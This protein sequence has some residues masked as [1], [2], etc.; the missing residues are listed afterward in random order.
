MTSQLGLDQCFLIEGNLASRGQLAMSGDIF[1]YQDQDGMG[2][3][4]GCC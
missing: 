4:L 2:R 3:G 1:D